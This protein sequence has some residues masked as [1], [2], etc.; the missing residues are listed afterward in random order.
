M[1]VQFQEVKELALKCGFSHV[2]DLEVSTIKLRTEVRDACATDKCGAYGK[3]W[4][5]PPGCGTLEE[6]DV[7]IRK[8]QRGVILQSTGEMEDAFDAETTVE[9]A[10]LHGERLEAFAE[11]LRKLYP[12]SMMIGAGACGRCETCTYPDKPCRFPEKISA[13]MEAL[14]MVVSDVCQDNNLPY[15]YG[16]NTITY[17]GCVLID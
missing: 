6:C 7:R 13:S 15:Y 10:R 1:A 3:R 17:T 9:T 8:Y 5:C 4:S 2:G 11:E 16:P 12:Q 14:G